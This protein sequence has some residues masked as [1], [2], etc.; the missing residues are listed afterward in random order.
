MP[1]NPIYVTKEAIAEKLRYRLPVR[2]S[3]IADPIYQQNPTSIPVSDALVDIIIEQKE[4]L[5]NLIL[6]QIYELP[7]SNQH[8]IITD[9]V[10]SLVIA[11]LL[12]I[13]FQGQ[14][15]SQLSGDLAGTGS[16]LKLY[17]YGLLQ[18]LTA[19][20]NIYIPGQPPIPDI[21]GSNKPQPIVLV[22]EVRRINYQNLDTITNAP[23]YVSKLTSD[24]VTNALVDVDFIG[25]YE[26]RY[27]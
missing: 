14:G 4:N 8:P 20:M 22:N 3:S 11:E 13:H 19:G 1:Y 12:R 5:V 6:Q 21:P 16:D 2:P 17:A 15:I 25:G 9:I 10:E 23:V 26:N 24:N 27:N 7:L 18:M